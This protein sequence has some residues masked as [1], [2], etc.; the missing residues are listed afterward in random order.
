MSSVPPLEFDKTYHGSLSMSHIGPLSPQQ[1]YL[2]LTDGRIMGLL[3]DTLVTSS[4]SNVAMSP[5]KGTK[6]DV[7]LVPPNGGRI[8]R[9]EVKTVTKNGLSLEPSS[10]KGVGRVYDD[11]AY[12]RWRKTVDG[13]VFVHGLGMPDV[14]IRA[15]RESDPAIASHKFTINQLHRAWDPAAER[16]VRRLPW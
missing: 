13:F 10:M 16:S 2:L 8:L 9:L 7:Q 1:T 12:R 4:F 5:G 3:A 14:Y 11:D 15:F 6:H